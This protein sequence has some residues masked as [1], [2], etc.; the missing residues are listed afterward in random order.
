MEIE[1]SRTRV[2]SFW[3]TEACGTHFVEKYEDKRDFFDQPASVRH[4][5][6]PGLQNRLVSFYRRVQ[7]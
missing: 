1:P 7:M 6:I 2:H 5:K 3:N 4:W